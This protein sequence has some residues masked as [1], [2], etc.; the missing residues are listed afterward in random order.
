MVTIREVA[1][2]AGV[3]V[4]TVSRVLNKK[5][6]VSPKTREKVEQSIHDLKYKPN[7][8]ARSLFKGKSKMIALL[9]PDI[10]NPFFPE[11]ARSVE[12]ICNSYGYTFVL[13][14]TDH[15]I[16]KELAYLNALQQKS[17]DGL[18]IVSSTLTGEHTKEINVP[19]I[20]LDRTFDTN[21]SN[22]KSNNRQ[23]ARLAAEHLKVIDCKVIAHITGPENASNTEERKQGYLDVVKDEEWFSTDYIVSGDYNMQK[24]KDAIKK[25]L[26]EHPEI[27]GLF[28]GNDVMGAGALKAIEELEMQVPH[29]I[30]IIGFDGISLG[31]TTTPTLTTVA[32]PIYKM[33]SRA[34]ELLIEQIN[35]PDIPKKTV[36]FP[37]ELI[38]RQSTR[39]RR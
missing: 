35:D 10:M 27:D 11:L 28:V 2:R 33:G 34:A 4:A 38:E 14:N 25:L 21:L 9:V 37:V 36:E 30:S 23:G 22:V 6:Y 19:I 3:S 5:G 1:K 15:S 16:E 26:L 29:D 8:V 18:I 32:Q 20:S 17:V 7:D 12:D 13:C 39:K 24:A 31:E